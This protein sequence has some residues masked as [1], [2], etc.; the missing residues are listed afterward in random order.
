MF[1][2]KFRWVDFVK[3]VILETFKII[4]D[5]TLYLHRIIDAILIYFILTDTLYNLHYKCF[6]Y[7]KENVMSY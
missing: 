4:Y 1:S 6:K 2:E 5:Y 7:K 3:S